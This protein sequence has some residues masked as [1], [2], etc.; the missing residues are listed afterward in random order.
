MARKQKQRLRVCKVCLS[1]VYAS[2]DWWYHDVMPRLVATRALE[3]AWE[4]EL[5]DMLRA[6][7]GQPNLPPSRLI[8]ISTAMN[9]GSGFSWHAS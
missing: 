4:D 8:E 3:T 5:P 6:R 9:Q 1:H 2:G 7:I